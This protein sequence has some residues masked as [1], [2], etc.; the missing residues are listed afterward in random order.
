MSMFSRPKMGTWAVNSEKDPRWNKTGR[1]PGL[2]SMGGPQEMRDW[3]A[4]CKKLYG[5]P[6]EDATM[7]FFKD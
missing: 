6:P 3:I 4:K 1:A 2:I 7:S 5:D